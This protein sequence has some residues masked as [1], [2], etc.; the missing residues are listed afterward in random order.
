MTLER[1]YFKGLEIRKAQEGS[2]SIGTLVGYAAVFNQRS[3]V[4]WDFVE[5]VKPGAFKQ[6]LERGDDIR[7]LWQHNWDDVLGRRST[8]TLRIQED[9]K[10]LAV[11]IDIPDT[12]VG[13]DVKTLVERRDVDGQSFGFNTM[14]D[15]WTKDKDNGLYI[16]ELIQVDLFD[17]GPVTVPAYS[18][19]SVEARSMVEQLIREVRS[20]E[21]AAMTPEQRKARDRKF[22]LWQHEKMKSSGE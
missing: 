13:R 16:R 3:Q 14:K 9:D 11:E 15:N 17:V 20:K 8:K 22:F 19:T 21:K 18:G 5:V 7:A 1:R 4:L 6:S 10:G 2:L 12:Q